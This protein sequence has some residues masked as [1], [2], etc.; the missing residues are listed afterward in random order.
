[1]L[2]VQDDIF[3]RCMYNTRPDVELDWG[4]S[5]HSPH[6]FGHRSCNHPSGAPCATS[7]ES[8]AQK[9]DADAQSG[10]APE[11]SLLTCASLSMHSVCVLCWELHIIPEQHVKLNSIPW[12]VNVPPEALQSMPNAA[13]CELHW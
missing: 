7:I 6:V 2:A 4:G 12:I 11:V 5:A 10:I 13:A 9:P 3:T 1:M 8:S